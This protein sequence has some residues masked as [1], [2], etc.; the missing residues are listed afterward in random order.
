MLNG[1][2]STTDPGYHKL[3]KYTYFL[4][5]GELTPA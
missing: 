1:G 4:L 5:P 2:A 3:E